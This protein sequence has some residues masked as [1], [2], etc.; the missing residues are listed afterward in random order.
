MRWQPLA[1]L[2]L[3]VALC[4]H[5]ALFV[6]PANTVITPVVDRNDGRGAYSRQ[7]GAPE[8]APDVYGHASTLIANATISLTGFQSLTYPF[9]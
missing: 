8:R 3:F 5:T 7:G 2:F 9:M 6:H 4:L 1:S